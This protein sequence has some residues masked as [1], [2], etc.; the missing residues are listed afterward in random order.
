MVDKIQLRTLVSPLASN[1]WSLTGTKSHNCSPYDCFWLLFYTQGDLWSF[2]Q[3]Q[4]V[5]RPFPE[6]VLSICPHLTVDRNVQGF[7][8]LEDK[9]ITLVFSKASL[10]STQE[11]HL[12]YC[13]QRFGGS[14]I[15]ISSIFPMLNNNKNPTL[16]SLNIWNI[17]RVNLYNLKESII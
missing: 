1:T 16:R 2:Q 8:L 17:L 15:P 4:Y 7:I 5:S 9:N 12:H 13:P 3:L 11:W 6:N 14:L 10:K